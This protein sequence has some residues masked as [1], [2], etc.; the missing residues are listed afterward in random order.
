MSAARPAAL[1]NTRNCPHCKS[2]V[3][4]SASICPACQH[5]LRF[6]L[7][8]AQPA[9]SGYAALQIDGTVRHKQPDEAC[10]FCVVLSIADE[11]GKQISRQ[12]V[13]VGVLQPE[14]MRR[15]SVSVNLLPARAPQLKPA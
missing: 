11:G 9:P 4:A 13:S 7:P 12:V 15:F 6:N 5:H 2:T 8:S 1:G 14:E 10:E 3:L